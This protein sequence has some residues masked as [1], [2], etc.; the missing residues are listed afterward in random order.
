M[1]SPAVPLTGVGPTVTIRFAGLPPSLTSE[2]VLPAAQV[3]MPDN[4]SSVKGPALP[5]SRSLQLAPE[6]MPMAPATTEATVPAQ[7]Q[8]AAW[9]ALLTKFGTQQVLKHQWEWSAGGYLPYYRYQPVSQICDI[10][11]EWAEGLNGYLSV[12]QLTENW[13][14]RWRRNEGGQKTEGA[15]RKKVVDLVME[16]SARPRWNAALALRFLAEKYEAKFKARSFCDY[17]QKNGG[18]GYQEVARAA[19]S[20]P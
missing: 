7:A 5:V 10:W 13:G 11:T 19:L 20:Y 9:L 18:S 3:I 17:L 8:Q 4:G 1:P 15:R 6:T 12:R 14:A 2:A 16:L